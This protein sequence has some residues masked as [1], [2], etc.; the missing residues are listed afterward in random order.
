[1]NGLYPKGTEF[2]H[3]PRNPL[4]YT[5]LLKLKETGM[6]KYLGLIL[7]NKAKVCMTCK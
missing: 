4:M 6:K 3:A 5:F 2:K 1:M 7:Y